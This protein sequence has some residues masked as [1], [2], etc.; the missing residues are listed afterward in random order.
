MASQ[1][2]TPLYEPERL[3][4]LLTINEVCELL[5]ISR[6]SVYGL[7]RAGELTPVR[8]GERA[9]FEP[10]DVRAYIERRREL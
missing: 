8:V 4:R 2:H 3:E 9:R 5:G 7:M 6:A 10:V 1:A